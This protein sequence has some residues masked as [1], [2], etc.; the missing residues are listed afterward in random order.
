MVAM[1]SVCSGVS[2]LLAAV[3]KTNSYCTAVIDARDFKNKV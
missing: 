1:L 3:S 2:L